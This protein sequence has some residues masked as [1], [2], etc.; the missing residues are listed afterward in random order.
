METAFKTW[1]RA[2]TPEGSSIEC[3]R[4]FPRVHF[5]S[6]N[7]P[8]KSLQH[9]TKAFAMPDGSCFGTPDAEV[10]VHTRC[11]YEELVRVQETRKRAQGRLQGV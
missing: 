8:L 6:W 5:R 7:L 9:E 11:R 10:H 4:A 2:R 1:F 3:N